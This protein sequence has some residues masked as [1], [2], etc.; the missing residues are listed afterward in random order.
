MVSGG[1]W[2]T[3]DFSSA[4]AGLINAGNL[5][6]AFSD[7][8]TFHVDRVADSGHPVDLSSDS[9]VS[10]IFGQQGALGTYD[11]QVQVVTVQHPGGTPSYIVQIPGTQDWSPVRGDNPVDLTTN[12]Y[13][14]AARDTKMASAVE[15]AMAAAGI[16]PDADVMLTGHSQG[17]ITA[18]TL[19]TDAGFMDRYHVTSV[20]T[21]G[22][23]IGRIPIPDDVSVLSVE[24]DQD[25]VPR[26]EGI[27]NPDRSSWIT[28]SRHL[29]DAEGETADGT[30]SVAAAHLTSAYERTG[31]DIDVSVDE[32]IERW[33]A[34][35]AQFFTSSGEATR[36]QIT[37]DD[38]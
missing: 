9:F 6:G 35:N 37:R 4:V 34:D 38:P 25:V 13:L 24:H 21:G 2:P 20:V 18:A 29:T 10:T 28:V 17:G 8:G 5:F 23:P 1:E 11:G 30:H 22:S 7:D 3:T 12:V 27:D 19:T 16:P 15:D 36:Y 26:L 31:H 32:S 33:R 14:E